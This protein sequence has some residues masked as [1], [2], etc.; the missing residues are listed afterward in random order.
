MDARESTDNLHL[1]ISDK[2]DEDPEL[3]TR[4]EEI[5][6][7]SG[8]FGI[9][10]LHTTSDV[11]QLTASGDAGDV[12]PEAALTLQCQALPE[13]TFQKVDHGFGTSYNNTLNSTRVYSRVRN[14]D[15]DAV[16]T[17][18]TSRTR[19]WSILSG[20]SIA[21]VS[22]VA[23][24]SLPLYE[25]ELRKVRQLQPRVERVRYDLWIDNIVNL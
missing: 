12:L 3:A 4:L 14:R 13:L 21:D 8:T 1:Y 23:V 16:S 18:S 19:A 11:G 20:V 22:I 2:V 6:L 24:I 25:P 5:Q 10:T 17:V 7:R 9:Q 15:V